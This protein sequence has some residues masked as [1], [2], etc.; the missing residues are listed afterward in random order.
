[1]TFTC[2][3]QVLCDLPVLRAPDFARPFSL[4][5]DASQVGVGAVLLQPDEQ[6]VSLAICYFSKKFTQAQRNYSVIE[7]ESLAIILALQ[8]F[9]IYIP[10]YG[11]RITI[12]ADHSPLRFFDKFKFKIGLSPVGACFCKNII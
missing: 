10:A 7:Q 6:E 8:H 3:K 9:D 5:V 11:P 1:M 4:A 2:V 12:F